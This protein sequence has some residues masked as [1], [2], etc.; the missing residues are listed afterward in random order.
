SSSGLSGLAVNSETNRIYVSDVN[1]SLV[2]VIDGSTNQVISDIA[3]SNP[4]T[5]A[6]DGHT[7]R[8]YV[9]SGNGLVGIDGASNT[10]LGSI[11]VSPVEHPACLGTGSGD[12][13]MAVNEANGRIYVATICAGPGT[14]TLPGL[15]PAPY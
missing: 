3:V 6:V 10:V 2:A 13:G 8:I 12:A 5:I 15:P 14:I 11:P 1:S 4:S 9:L 7:N